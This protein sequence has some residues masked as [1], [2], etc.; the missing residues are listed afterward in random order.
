MGSGPS[1]EVEQGG[2]GPTSSQGRNS[3]DCYP[4]TP[5]RITK[6][7]GPFSRTA[8]ALAKPG[9]DT[10]Y[11]RRISSGAATLTKVTNSPEPDPAR[12]HSRYSKA[13]T[14][15]HPPVKPAATPTPAAV[16]SWNHGRR[17]NGTSVGTPTTG[18]LTLA[19]AFTTA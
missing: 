2:G 4:D 19:L 8:T 3:A 6:A 18:Q 17:R 13:K 1:E 7:E 15:C 14:T 9:Q 10:Q 16:N 5:P 11:Q 12:S